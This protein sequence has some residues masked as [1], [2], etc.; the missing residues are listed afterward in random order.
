MLPCEV[1]ALCPNEFQ[2]LPEAIQEAVVLRGMYDEVVQDHLC[3][4]CPIG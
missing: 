4:D 3:K 1:C 2:K